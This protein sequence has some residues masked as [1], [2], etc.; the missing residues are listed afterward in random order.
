MSHRLI[1]QI[2]VLVLSMVALSA[3][4]LGVQVQ[5]KYAYFF[6]IFGK[7][8][9]VEISTSQVVAHG[10]LMEIKGVR[11]FL[12]NWR[13]KCETCRVRYDPKLH[14]LYVLTYLDFH[15]LSETMA[16]R[17]LALEF[18]SFRLIGKVDIGK[19]KIGD[20]GFLITPDGRHLL[21]SYEIP[22]QG[23]SWTFVKETYNTR[24]LERVELKQE[25][26]PRI[27]YDPVALA[28]ARFSH[29]AYFAP[30]GT[31]IYDGEYAIQGE[32][33]TRRSKPR[34]PAEVERFVKENPDFSRHPPVWLGENGH[35]MLLWETKSRQRTRKLLDE[36]MGK[37][38]EEKYTI[39]YATGRLAL[40][41]TLV[42]KKV[43]LWRVEEL[44]GDAPQLIAVTPNG[45]LVYFA[46]SVDERHAELYAVDLTMK[47]RP[48]RLPLF[49]LD[50]Y[51]TS[52][53]FADQ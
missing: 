49:G 1:Q 26:I 4:L 9:K 12:P 47:G 51:N 19:V 45:Q 46:K 21:I 48:V 42:G 25:V 31:T 50:I 3:T 53:F 29:K 2:A 43:R 20:V 44:E 15:P 36:S 17:I 24:N 30:D 41:D 27:P 39:E 37:S 52:C 34:L 8:I 40:Y 33:V 11:E 23:Q 32:R 28:R 22:S 5:P 14:R 38:K 35:R 16:L 6:D 13:G 18:P 7:F 10:S